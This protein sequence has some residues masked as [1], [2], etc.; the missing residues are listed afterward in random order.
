MRW[1]QGH[2]DNPPVQ[3]TFSLLTPFIAYLPAERLHASGVLAA[4]AAGIFLGWHSPLTITARTRLQAY[5]RMDRQKSHQGRFFGAVDRLHAEYNERIEQLEICA[6]NPG[7]C[8]GG[9]ATPQYQRLQHE[10]L[11]VERKT[12]IRLRNDHV[13]NDEA[14]RRIQRDLDLAEA[15]LSGE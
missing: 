1:V 6:D 9:I 13:I 2:L 3:I 5:A 10:A 15:R 12:I 7:T 8:R 14:L 11:R 4:V